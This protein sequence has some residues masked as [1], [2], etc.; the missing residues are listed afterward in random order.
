MLRLA[1][2]VHFYALVWAVCEF[3]MPGHVLDVYINVGEDGDGLANG[4]SS[5]LGLHDLSPPVSA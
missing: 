4:E 5:S 1:V 2:Q 3:V